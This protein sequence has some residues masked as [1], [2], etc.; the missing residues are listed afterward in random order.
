MPLT[1]QFN[2]AGSWKSV[3]TMSPS[4]SADDVTRDGAVDR[5][6]W[7]ST[8]LLKTADTRG[9]TMRLVD[10]EKVVVAMSAGAG[11]RYYPFGRKT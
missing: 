10:D 4:T 11:W 3:M 6:C 5:V 1:L 9:A 7:L 2:T 8:E